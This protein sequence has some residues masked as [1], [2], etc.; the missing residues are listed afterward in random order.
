MDNSL[1]HAY[2]DII[3]I[4]SW[5][6]KSKVDKCE[7]LNEVNI[8][9]EKIIEPIETIKKH[10]T[11]QK[12]LTPETTKQKITAPKILAPEAIIHTN[13]EL[14]QIINNCQKCPSRE[15][16]LNALIG[17]GNN[18]AKIFVI[19]SAPTAE[20][21]RVG[22][23]FS[24]RSESLFHAMLNSVSLENKVYVSGLL[25]CY[26]MTNFTMSEQELNLCS[27]YLHVQIEQIKPTILFVLGAFEAQS[28]LKT[29]ESFN[30]LRGR[31]HTMKINDQDYSVI[32]S[33]HPDYLL[34]NPLYKKQSLH[35]LIML[36]NFIK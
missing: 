4:Q 3:G 28:L 5:C 25:K 26:S 14:N 11:I 10:H 20:E 13:S 23:Y 18:H 1:R 24:G 30:N 17:Q 8:S 6:L 32:V 7:A 21:D 35:D 36:K 31:V 15:Y 12:I 29:Q 16:R 19:T 33:Y 34:R 2:L 22:H 9:Q 27:A